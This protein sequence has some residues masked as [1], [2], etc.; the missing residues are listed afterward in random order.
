MIC[1]R[2]LQRNA[3]YVETLAHPDRGSGTGRVRIGCVLGTIS[4]IISVGT[5]Q[6]AVAADAVEEAV[7][8]RVGVK[9]FSLFLAPKA[10][11]HTGT[12]YRLAVDKHLNY[13]T[14]FPQLSIKPPLHFV[15]S[16]KT[17]HARLS[18]IHI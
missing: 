4:S 13:Y 11:C 2:E 1:A 9:G 6:L 18:A 14:F 17:N 7:V 16:P 15:H 12:R 8:V 5:Q 3:A 10:L